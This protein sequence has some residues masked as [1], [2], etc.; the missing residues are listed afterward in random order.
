MRNPRPCVGLLLQV[1]FFLSMATTAAL[2]LQGQ[3]VLVTGAGRGIGQAIAL[4]CH[5]EG[6]KVAICART[7]AQLQETALQISAD[8]PPSDRLFSHTADVTKEDQ[9]DALVQAVVEKW[10]GIDILINNAGRG[11][12]RKGHLTDALETDDLRQILDLNVVAVHLVTAA[13]VPHMPH[14]RGQ[15]LNVSSRAG[16]MGLPGM[17]FYVASKFALEG[18]TASWAAELLERGI[19]VNSISPGMVDTASF[20]KADPLK[21]GVRTAASIADGMFCML[22]SDVSGHYLHVDELDA[23]RA[24]GYPDAKALKPINE[25]DFAEAPSPPLEKAPRKRHGARNQHKTKYFLRWL[26]QTFPEALAAAKMPARQDEAEGVPHTKEET[27]ATA[28]EGTRSA[29]K[30]A[31]NGTAAPLGVAQHGEPHILD[32]AGGKGELSARLVYCHQQRVVLVDPRPA[33]LE[34]CYEQLIFKGLPN[35][36]QRRLRARQ[37]TQ[38]TLLADRLQESFGQL[39]VY[40]TAETL[41]TDDKLRVAVEQA[42]LVLGMH[43]DGATEAIVDVA[44]ALGKPFCVVPCCVFPNFFPQRQFVHATSGECRPVRSHA[45]FCAYL[46][47]KDPRLRQSILPFEGRN[48]AIW[49]EG[50]GVPFSPVANE[51]T[52]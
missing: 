42:S 16:K 6:A 5:Q 50:S 10:G 25:P 23:A 20:P 29:P 48:V 2:K 47:Q 19:R 3:R 34:H 45:D 44:L 33:D 7:E 46:L 13:T 17:S 15:I 24:K 27:S 51:E 43:A 35:K 41:R 39:T 14:G 12:A 26:L 18:L 49:W 1:V 21:P 37:A 38:P 8:G 28:E 30:Q 36:W 9:V 11:Q 40:L 31:R 22:Q 52:S 4:L 32:V